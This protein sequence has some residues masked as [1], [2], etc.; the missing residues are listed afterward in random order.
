MRAEFLKFGESFSVSAIPHAVK[1]QNHII[2]L[3]WVTAI[4]ICFEMMLYQLSKNFQVYLSHPIMTTYG[5]GNENVS[6]PDVTVCNL[7]HMDDKIGDLTWFDYIKYVDGIKNK[8]TLD[9]LKAKYCGNPDIEVICQFLN[10]LSQN[11]MNEIWK[12]I[13]VVMKSISWCKL[14][15]ARRPRVNLKFE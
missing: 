11:D 9:T 15:P 5:D 2:R 1:S 10:T 8:T 12:G 3:I 6:F 7:F 14:N 4:L 13:K